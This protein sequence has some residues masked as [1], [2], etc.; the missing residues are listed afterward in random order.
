MVYAPRAVNEPQKLAARWLRAT[1]PDSETQEW[2]AADIERVTG[3][4]I[5]RDRYS[6]YESGSLPIGKTVLKH[7]VD[8]WASRGV[9][10]PNAQPEPSAGTEANVPADLAAALDR[11]TAELEAM[12][13]ERE[14]WRRGVVAVLRGYEGGQVPEALLDALVPRLPEDAR[15]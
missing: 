8:Y 1:R 9:P 15:R 7:F 4:H 3:W 6:K 13:L 11:L 12:R 14:A 2:L 10:G 5:T